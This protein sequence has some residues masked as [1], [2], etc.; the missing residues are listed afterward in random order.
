MFNR[1]PCHHCSDMAGL[2][3]YLANTLDD[4][5]NAVFLT[6]EDAG[7][8]TKYRRDELRREQR[9]ARSMAEIFSAGLE[10]ERLI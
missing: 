2:I 7:F 1:K 10:S 6:A 4:S 5:I 9:T 8:L 3:Q